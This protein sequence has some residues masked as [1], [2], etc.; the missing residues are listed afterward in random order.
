MA[1]IEGWE[2]Y[3]R[4]STKGSTVRAHLHVTTKRTGGHF[5]FA[6]AFETRVIM[7]SDDVIWSAIGNQFCSYKVRYVSL[8]LWSARSS[9][10]PSRTVTQNFCRNEYNVTGFCSRQSCPLAN[11]RYATVREHEGVYRSS[12][13]LSKDVCLKQF[14]RCTLLVREDDRASTFPSTYVGKDQALKQLHK[15]TGTG[16]NPPIVR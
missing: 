15:S 6:F 8:R 13:L 14:R 3:I 11:S 4:V 12:S 7:Q 5:C 2:Q 16:V 9:T 10:G 1:R